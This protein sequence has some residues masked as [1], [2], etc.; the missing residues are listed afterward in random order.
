MRRFVFF[1][2]LLALAACGAATAA[3]D[4]VAAGG[5]IFTIQCGGCHAISDVG[6]DALG[7]R[8]GAMAARANAQPDPAAWLRSSIISP[9]AE[10]APGYQPG[11]MPV[12][13]G[14]S[15][16]PGEIDALV[17]YMLSDGG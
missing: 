10:V 5:R 16:R 15:L 2:F 3:P 11:L 9:N 12:S 1:L 17:A 14:Q 4:P 8:L 6:P 13:Y 7:P